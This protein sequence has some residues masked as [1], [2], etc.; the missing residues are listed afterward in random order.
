M[1]IE[2]PPSDSLKDLAHR[3]SSIFAEDKGIKDFLEKVISGQVA[4]DSIGK[5]EKA[6]SATPL[7]FQKPP[8]EVKKSDGNASEFLSTGTLIPHERTL[9]SSAT[10]SFMQKIGE[11]RILTFALIIGIIISIILIWRWKSKS[12]S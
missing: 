9:D 11:G 4:I 8:T 7:A 12:T 10:G 3:A 2:H 1:W 5:D 6:Q